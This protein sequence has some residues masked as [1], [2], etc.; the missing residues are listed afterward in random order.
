[1]RDAIRQILLHDWD[2]HN[3]A[4]RPEAHGTYDLYIDPL[5]QLLQSGADDEAIIDFLHSREQ[6]TMCFPSSGTRRLI[7]V[8]RKL[9]HAALKHD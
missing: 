4:S 6:E 1:M 5:I 8:A 7:P 9:R 2:P 3:V